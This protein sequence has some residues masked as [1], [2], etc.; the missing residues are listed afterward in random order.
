MRLL[1]GS[2]ALTLIRGT[3]RCAALGVA[4]VEG[5]SEVTFDTCLFRNVSVGGADSNGGG[6]RW[7]TWLGALDLMV[8]G[9]SVHS[10]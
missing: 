3:T 4:L 6:T 8:S 2:F 5:G 1:R 9:W 10:S 7:L